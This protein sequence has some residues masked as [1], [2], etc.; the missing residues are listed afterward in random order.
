MI[1]SPETLLP[2]L[3]EGGNVVGTLSRKEAHSGS[4]LLHPVVHL[5]VFNSDGQL[6]LQQRPSWK[7]IQPGKWDTSVGGHMDA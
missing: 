6:Y 5:H 7:D 1:D 4:R 2:L 3:D